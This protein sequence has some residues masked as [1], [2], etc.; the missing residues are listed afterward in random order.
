MILLIKD[1]SASLGLKQSPLGNQAGFQSFSLIPGFSSPLSLSQNV[2]QVEGN[3]QGRCRE[4]LPTSRP[5]WPL[6]VRKLFSLAFGPTLIPATD[7]HSPSVV[8]ATCLVPSWPK[9]RPLPA[10]SS[11]QPLSISHWIS[12]RPCT[13]PWERKH[14]LKASRCLTIAFPLL[15]SWPSSKWKAGYT[16]PLPEDSPTTHPGQLCAYTL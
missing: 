13:G 7:S 3:L 16:L 2:T 15:C 10:H 5:S 14:C 6:L 8:K 9:A 11:C 4:S 1:I 12:Y